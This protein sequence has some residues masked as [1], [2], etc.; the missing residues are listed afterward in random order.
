MKSFKVCLHE[1]RG[2]VRPVRLQ[3]LV[4]VLIGVLR[5]A[6]SLLFVWTSKAL[7]DIATGKSDAELRSYVICMVA[8]ILVQIV[9]GLSA[10]YWE[11]YIVLKN[12]N[13]MRYRYFEHVL[14]SVWN[15]RESF[16]SGDLVNRITEDVRVMVDLLCTRIPDII[17]TATQLA[18]ASVFLFILAPNL[19]W[20]LIGLMAVAVIGS[21]LFFGKLR[22]LT[23]V[24]REKESLAQQHIQE[25]LQNRVLVLTLTGTEKVLSKLGFIQKEIQDNTVTRLNYNATARGFMGL[26]FM[27][28]YAAAFLWGVFGIRSGAV[29][30]GMM[31]AF[32]Q[33][34]GQVQRPIAD[35]ARHVPAFIHSLTSIERLGDLMD[36]PLEEK[37]Q[38][39]F[40]PH[41]PEIKVS[42][43]TFA[44]PDQDS[45]VLKDFSYTFE[46]GLMTEVAGPTGIGKSTL[47][48]LVLAL[49]K[50]QE[51]E[52]LID[53][54]PV[55][56]DTR[57]NFMYVPQGNSLISGT[58]RDNLMLA[59]GPS[60]EQMKE[61]LHIAV[62]DFVLDLPDGLDSRCGESGSGLSE[63]QSQRIAIA[64][65][66]LCR[67]NVLILD[68]S[69]SALDPAT[70]QQLLS[71][72]RD[73]TAGRKT[74]IFI[75]H[76][77]SVARVCDRI[78]NI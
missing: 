63:G 66:L 46:S 11:N 47:V 23:E 78:L 69:T 7:V 14:S 43:M 24:I 8:I 2:M 55:S 22:R 67:G 17:V 61:A 13:A 72:L 48:R 4:S 10:S 74:V 18:A 29:T 38:P 68:E 42:G 51:G 35:L 33:L 50:P 25:S 40:C 39:L 57:C 6:A 65:A 58:I 52:I 34:V 77:E 54:T 19:L 71:N 37:G 62:A 76:R 44:Y 26:G 15:G 27:S 59:G 64:R 30:F 49:L 16:H 5:I 9:S 53:G 28:G 1:L 21:I 73:Y 70:E 20:I 12:T 45:P 56:A 3:I 32:L 31:T 41:A 60:E 36:M 75:S